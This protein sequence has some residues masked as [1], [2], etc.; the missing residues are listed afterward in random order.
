MFSSTM[1][2]VDLVEYTGGKVML[3]SLVADLPPSPPPLSHVNSVRQVQ[4]STVHYSTLYCSTV[5][6]ST[7]HRIAVQYIALQI[8]QYIVVQ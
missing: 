5:H 6:C 7:V 2:G 4:Y 8:E 3:D 1:S